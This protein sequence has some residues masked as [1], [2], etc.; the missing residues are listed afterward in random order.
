[1]RNK[2]HIRMFRVE[3]GQGWLRARQFLAAMIP[4]NC[5]KRAGAVGLPKKSMQLPRGPRKDNFLWLGLGYGYDLS[6]GEKEQCKKETTCCPS[7]K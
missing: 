3:L 4:D 5:G 6:E 1:M 2:E 7:K